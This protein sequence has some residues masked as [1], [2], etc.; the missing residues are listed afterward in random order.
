MPRRRPTFQARRAKQRLDSRRRQPRENTM[1]MHSRRSLYEIH[2]IRA[3]SGRRLRRPPIARIAIP[4][5]LIALRRMLRAFEAEL[6]ARHAIAELA[7][8]DDICSAIWALPEAKS[9]AWREGS[10][11][12]M[13]TRFSQAITVSRSRAC[14][15]DGLKIS[16]TLFARASSIRCE[17][18]SAG[19]LVEQLSSKTRHLVPN[20]LAGA[21]LAQTR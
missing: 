7:S 8:L 19:Y 13:T 15:E 12:D 4:Q 16:F 10:D 21:I 14:L 2:G 3:R 5:I 1:E 9:R 20:N 18:R 6:A 17:H 11:R